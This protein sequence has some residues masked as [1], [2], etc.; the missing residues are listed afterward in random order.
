[1]KK[2]DKVIE[3]KEKI[4]SPWT[5]AWKRL[6]KNKLSMAGLYIIIA[7]ILIAIIGPIVYP[8]S[9][10]TTDLVNTFAKPSSEH[11]LGTDNVGRDVL[12]RLMYGGRISLAVGFIAVSISVAIGTIL[13]I[14]AGYYGGIV[15]TIIMRIVDIFLCFPFLPL[16]LMVSA[17]MSDNSVA[18]DKRMYIVM[19]I[20]GVLSWPSLCRLVRG[21]ILSLREQE[22]MQAAEALGLSDRRKMFVQFQ[23]H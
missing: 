11:L 7:L 2:D 23:L 18:P 12:A 16:L 21:Q 5:V 10:E 19:V 17:M 4:E 15:D 14:V 9:W 13:G 8:Q 22:F 6:K 1:M 3:K 20:I